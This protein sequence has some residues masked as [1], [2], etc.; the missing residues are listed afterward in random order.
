[1]AAA[2][3]SPF[4]WATPTATV[5][6]RPAADADQVAAYLAPFAA[7]MAASVVAAAFAPHDQWLYGLKV[8]A[9]GATVWW[10]RDAYL[11]LVSSVAPISIAAGL[12]IGVAWI[13][14]DPERG[15]ASPI[16]DWLASLP[17][18]LAVVWI[19]L[20]AF[21]SVA[22]VPIAEELAFRGYLCRLLMSFRFSHLTPA[23]LRLIAL[24]V[25]S[26]AFGVLHERWLAATLSGAVYAA[27]MF[28]TNRLSDPIAAHMAS[29]GLIM[30][31]SVAAGQWTLL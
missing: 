1:M 31:W 9:I 11:R 26:V 15:L 20:R 6:R 13:A 23:H 19:A 16:G 5:S 29:N 14:T 18:W 24:I 21:G 17:M 8:A 2:R 22:L 12:A 10:F 25:S 3:W 28:R 4:V 7:F 27:L 30:F